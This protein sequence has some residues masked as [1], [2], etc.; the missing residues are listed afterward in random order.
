MIC[1]HS[2][3]HTIDGTGTFNMRKIVDRGRAMKVAER[4]WASKLSSVGVAIF[5]ISKRLE[6]WVLW[7]KM[8]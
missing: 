5:S 7:K 8:P 3:H 6:S 4:I 1:R 2:L